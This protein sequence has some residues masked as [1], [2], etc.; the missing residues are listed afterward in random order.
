VNGGVE[1]SKDRRSPNQPVAKSSHW[2][3]NKGWGARIKAGS[4]AESSPWPARLEAMPSTSKGRPNGHQAKSL[5]EIRQ[6][7]SQT[8]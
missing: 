7:R 3:A 2:L 5:A 6:P 4:A 8:W 1:R